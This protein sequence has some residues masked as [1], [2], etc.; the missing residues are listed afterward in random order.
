MKQDFLMP[1]DDDDGIFLEKA[2]MPSGIM[3]KSYKRYYQETLNE[4]PVRTNTGL[5][6]AYDTDGVN[7]ED[8]KT[9][10]KQYSNLIIGMYVFKTMKMNIYSFA[11]N[12]IEKFYILISGDKEEKA[13]IQGYIKYYF[14]ANKYF[15]LDGVWHKIFLFGNG[16]MTDFT[17]NWLFKQHKLILSGNVT[18][19]QGEKYLKRLINYCFNNNIETGIYSNNQFQK[20]N[21]LIDNVDDAWTKKG[22]NKQIYFRSN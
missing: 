22:L 10:F 18:T 7:A 5:E 9:L 16:M 2:E 12:S 8:A 21:E 20:F 11:K 14:D 3:S 19:P 13:Y 4:S 17:T 6:V 1:I 15:T